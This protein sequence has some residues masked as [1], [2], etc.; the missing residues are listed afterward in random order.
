MGMFLLLKNYKRRSRH[1]RSQMKYFSSKRYA[2]AGQNSLWNIVTSSRD[3]YAN[4]FNK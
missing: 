3:G 2:S 4:G 1:I